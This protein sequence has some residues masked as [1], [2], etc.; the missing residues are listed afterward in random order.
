VWSKLVHVVADSIGSGKFPAWASEDH[1]CDSCSMAYART[2][3]DDAVQAIQALP[4]QLRA[5]VIAVPPRTRR[6]RPDPSIWS[7]AEYACHIR[8][9]LISTTI[10]LH[11]GRTESAPAVDPMFNDLRAELFRYN[12][13]NL[14]A[15]LEE[16]SA[17]TAGLCEEISRMHDPDW[18]R[19]VLRQP[20][21][22]RTSRWL[23]RQAMHEGLHHLADI[24]AVRASLM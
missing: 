23:V 9:V 13:A 6:Q 16:T 3:V 24:A 17:I 22:Q 21:E 11:R 4:V 5:A 14:M 20:N 15:V 1:V 10:R 18:D 2:R 19:V 12:Q 8:D 7:V